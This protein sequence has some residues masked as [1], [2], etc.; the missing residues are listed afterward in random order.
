MKRWPDLKETLRG[1]RWA[2]IGAVATRLYMPERATAD[3]DVLIS[4]DDAGEVRQRLVRAGY[5]FQQELAIDGSSWRSPEGIPVDIV[6][7]SEPWTNQAL[8]AA[9]SNL[10]PQGMPVLP[11]PF[12]VLMKFR[13]A[14]VQDLADI[15]RMLGLS[16][17]NARD[18]VRMV[19]QQYE[20]E[21]LQDLESLIRLGVVETG[22]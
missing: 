4:A 8:L 12:L 17:E 19:F 22:K 13:A 5:A 1:V 10:D 6:E 21:G 15:T 3:L 20:P 7:T 11:L 18:E 16:N 9:E 2:M 14:R